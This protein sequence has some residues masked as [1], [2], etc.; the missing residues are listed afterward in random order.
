VVYYVHANHG[1]VRG[2]CMSVCVMCCILF[3]CCVCCDVVCGMCLLLWSVLPF[4]VCWRCVVSG[5]VIFEGVRFYVFCGGL[6][7]IP[8]SAQINDDGLGNHLCFRKAKLVEWNTFCP[9]EDPRS[10]FRSDHLTCNAVKEYLL[11][12][13]SPVMHEVPLQNLQKC[14]K[15][16][17][18][19]ATFGI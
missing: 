1:V 18:S 10:Y 14:M 19:S 12:L 3:R 4:L 5:K 15:D 17:E 9:N 16:S 11:G 7:R 6:C 8:P 13:A 2:L